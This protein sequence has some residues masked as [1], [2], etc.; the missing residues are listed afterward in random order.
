MTAAPTASGHASI[1][2]LTAS[3]PSPKN[4]APLRPNDDR[5]ERG[6]KKQGSSSRKDVKLLRKGLQRIDGGVRGD[7]ALLNIR[8]KVRT[9]SLEIPARVIGK[10]KKGSRLVVS[11]LRSGHAYYQGQHTACILKTKSIAEDVTN[12]NQSASNQS[13]QLESHRVKPVQG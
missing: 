7:I 13:D 10:R 6:R 12:S 11:L 3:Y 5:L 1:A 9:K 8:D 4:C 2:P